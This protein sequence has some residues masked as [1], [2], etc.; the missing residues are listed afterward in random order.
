MSLI[1]YFSYLLIT[2]CTLKL[3]S[4]CTLTYTL[5]TATRCCQMFSPIRLLPQAHCYILSSPKFFV[6]LICLFTWHNIISI[7]AH[8]LKIFSSEQPAAS[9]ELT[10]S[11][12]ASWTTNAVV[13]VVLG[14]ITRAIIFINF[15]TSHHRAVDRSITLTRQDHQKTSR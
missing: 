4:H 12:S 1:R 3:V 5:L 9:T 14:V 6:T 7:D 13:R 8:R 2:F 10:F 11:H 15:C